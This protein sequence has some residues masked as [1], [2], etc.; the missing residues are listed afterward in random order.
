MVHKQTLTMS[1]HSK[2]FGLGNCMYMYLIA[3]TMMLLIP[4]SLTLIF[5]QR[6][7]SV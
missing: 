6:L 1:K 7:E 3:G 5:K 4:P 2:E